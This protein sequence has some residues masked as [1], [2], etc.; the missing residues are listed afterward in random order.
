MMPRLVLFDI[1]GTLLR[2]CGLGRRSLESAFRDLYDREGAFE[3][4][5]FHG[6]TDK[7][8]LAD[9]LKRVG[10]PLED[11]DRAITAY[12]AHLRAEVADGPS[13]V[14]PGVL[15]LLRYLGERRDVILGLVTGNVRQG[16]EIK[17]S[18]DELFPWFRVGA[19]GDDD[20]DRAVLVRLARERA[21][22]LIGSPLEPS[23][24]LSIG[25]TEFD[26]AAARSAG[27][28]AVAV[29][30]GSVTRD[31]LVASTP[32]HLLDGL[33]PPWTFLEGYL[34]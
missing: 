9:G 15:D 20:S 24:V 7:D 19:Y 6:R 29:A 26:V 23:L 34:S 31:C 5:R 22:T 18:R 14:L 10:A 1:D 17:L 27:A 2:P 3:G 12:L 8:I 25:D 11:F 13:L 16:A 4:I 33:S 32:D 21:E 30:T 28:V